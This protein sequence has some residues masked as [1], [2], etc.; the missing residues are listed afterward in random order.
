MQHLLPATLSLLLWLPV[1]S[2]T[3]GLN[4]HQE[5]KLGFWEHELPEMGRV[6]SAVLAADGRTWSFRPPLQW[7]VDAP[8][9]GVVWCVAL[10]G[11]RIS[12]RLTQARGDIPAEQLREAALVRLPGEARIVHD[13]TCYTESESGPAFDF[14]TSVA[15]GSWVKGRLAYVRVGGRWFEFNLLTTPDSF[16]NHLVTFS[17]FLGSFQAHLNPTTTGAVE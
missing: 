5:V 17:V 15:G 2:A 13:T 11:S 12:L 3:T 1:V 7:T 8:D 4:S 16:R 14:T 10:D 6:Q 9:E